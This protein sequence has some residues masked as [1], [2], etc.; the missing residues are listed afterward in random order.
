MAPQPSL[1]KRIRRHITAARAFHTD[2]I[3]VTQRRLRVLTN[4][5]RHLNIL[6]SAGSTLPERLS[7]AEASRRELETLEQLRRSS[8]STHRDLRNAVK[9]IHYHLN[10]LIGRGDDSDRRTRPA[11]GAADIG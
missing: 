10:R 11:S 5:T 3:A 7:A 2:L 8:R 4:L 6:R 1:G 9:R